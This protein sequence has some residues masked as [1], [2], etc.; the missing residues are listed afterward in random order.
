MSPIFYSFLKFALPAA[1][2][3]ILLIRLGRRD[4]LQE[5]FRRPGLSVS[6]TFI[7][8]YL[9]WML[10]T[11]ALVGWRG[12]WDFGPW[13][14]APLPSSVFRVLGVVVAG[15]VLEELVFRG[16][17]FGLLLRTRIGGIGAVLA[18]ALIWSLI[19]LQYSATVIAIIFV[20]G[21]VLGLARW[22]SDSLF[23]PM[24]MHMLWNLYAI[25]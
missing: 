9:G 16:I 3:T 14:E 22:R 13:R 10:G 11:D 19:H 20:S 2:A 8:L 17:A 7:A 25:W 24:A 6:L 23:L 15:P 12:P 1:A 21:L 18:T 4:F 5:A